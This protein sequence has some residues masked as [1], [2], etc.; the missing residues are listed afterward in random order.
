M[1]WNNKINSDADIATQFMTQWKNS[2][3]HDNNM[4]AATPN[5]GATNV[6]EVN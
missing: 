4:K 2:P 6:V 3:G 1:F 5:S